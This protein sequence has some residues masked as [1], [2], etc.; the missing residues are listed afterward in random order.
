MPSESESVVSVLLISS[1]F[2]IIQA[3]GC[4]FFSRSADKENLFFSQNWEVFISNIPTN[5]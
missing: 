4:R 3:L 2:I 1:T 5:D